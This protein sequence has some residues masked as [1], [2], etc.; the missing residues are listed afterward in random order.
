MDRW[1]KIIIKKFWKKIKNLNFDLNFK[2]K[3][4]LIGSLFW[5]VWK[6]IWGW[7]LCNLDNKISTR[8]FWNFVAIFWTFFSSSSRLLL[9]FAFWPFHSHQYPLFGWKFEAFW[10]W[11]LISRNLEQSNFYEFFRSRS[12]LTIF[13]SVQNFVE[14]SRESWVHDRRQVWRLGI[15]F[16][17]F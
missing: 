3:I 17:I 11:K 10:D 8:F 15:R 9:L 1:L 5:C 4:T 2:Y 6:K 7:F 16:E 14:G 12:F 13:E